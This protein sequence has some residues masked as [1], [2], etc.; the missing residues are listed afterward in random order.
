MV[1]AKVLGA[2]VKKPQNADPLKL[3]EYDLAGFGSGIDSD[4]HYKALLGLA[5]ELPWTSQK[6]AFIF[7]TCGIPMV[8]AGRGSIEKYSERSHSALRE[9]LVSRGYAVIGEYSCAGHNTNS[10]LRFIGGLNKGRPN[11]ED[12]G[13]AEEFA[14]SLVVEMQ[15]RRKT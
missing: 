12:L 13:H 11:A 3:H 7:S 9:K 2:E 14:R 5:D 15:K 4:R 1:L 8:V 6:K 10:F